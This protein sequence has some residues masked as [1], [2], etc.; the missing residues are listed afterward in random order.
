MEAG[1]DRVW[2]LFDV[3]QGA[4][5]AVGQFDQRKQQ[6]PFGLSGGHV[7]I[8]FDPAPVVLEVRSRSQMALLLPPQ[9]AR[10][11]SRTAGSEPAGGDPSAAGFFLTLITMTSSSLPLLLREERSSGKSRVP[12]GR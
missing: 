6:I 12:E 7:A 4:I 9:L 5:E 8:A 1:S 3:S 10:R 2:R 11:P